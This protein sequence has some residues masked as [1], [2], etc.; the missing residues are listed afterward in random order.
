MLDRRDKE[1]YKRV[2]S[3]GFIIYR[4]TKDGPKF[5]IMYHRGDYWNF[6]KGRIEHLENSVETALRE[7]EEETG[8][9]P[10]EL[11]IREN[12]K[13][14][15]SFKFTM[16]K[17]KIQKV[18]T[19]YLAETHKKGID[20]SKGDKEEGFGWFLYRDARKLFANY[21]ESQ[22][23]LRKAYSFI[24]GKPH[25]QQKR[26]SEKRLHQRFAKRT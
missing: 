15:E 13:T 17:E 4:Q 9:K 11:K 20:I 19:L 3:A 7:L 14:H 8:L 16:G 6:P 23:V 2:P 10:N 18:V 12:F 25:Y 21:K 22:T 26:V 24:Q 1:V 5:L